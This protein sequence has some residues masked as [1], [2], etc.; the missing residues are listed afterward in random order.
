MKYDEMAREMYSNWWLHS[1]VSEKMIASIASALR[2]VERETLERA[3]K[4]CDGLEYPTTIEE[5][6]R[7]T[8]KEHIANACRQCAAAIRSLS[9]TPTELLTTQELADGYVRVPREASETMLDAGFQALLENHN[10]GP[11]GECTGLGWDHAEACYRA[12][13]QAADGI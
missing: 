7:M 11:Y 2:Q 8:K 5:W 9:P 10:T 4:V 13:I 3:A 1:K 6:M 12:M